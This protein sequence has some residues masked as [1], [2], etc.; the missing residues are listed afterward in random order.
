MIEN[1]THRTA[2]RNFARRQRPVDFAAEGSRLALCLHF[3]LR[4][5]DL[6]KGDEKG[7]GGQLFLAVLIARLVSL[8]ATGKEANYF[9]RVSH[10]VGTLS[11]V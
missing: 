4:N 3:Q 9:S 2:D 7:V 6:R 8:Y 1:S 11:G 10:V 5:P